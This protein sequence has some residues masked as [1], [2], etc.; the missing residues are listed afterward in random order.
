MMSVASGTAPTP[1]I[2]LR[3]D[4]EGNFVVTLPEG[5]FRLEF[6]RDGVAIA[7][8]T[9]DTRTHPEVFRVQTNN[10]G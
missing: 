6:H 3:T 2:A 9:I 5:V 1:E 4:P 8:E 10:E 7:A